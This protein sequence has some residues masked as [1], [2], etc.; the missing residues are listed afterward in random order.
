MAPRDEWRGHFERLKAEADK[1]AAYAK[2]QREI[3][4][5]CKRR[6]DHLGA[7][8]AGSKASE[9][10]RSRDERKAEAAKIKQQWGFR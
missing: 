2:A 10:R 9:F 3:A 5:A 8:I 1:F 7:L 4:L 6:R